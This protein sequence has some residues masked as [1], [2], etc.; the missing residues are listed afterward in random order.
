MK[1]KMIGEDDERRGEHQVQELTNR[2]IAETDRIGKQKEDDIL[3][4]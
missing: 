1:E 4:V 2:Y 3:E